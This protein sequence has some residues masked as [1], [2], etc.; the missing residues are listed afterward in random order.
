VIHNAAWYEVGISTR[1]QIFFRML[2]GRPAD[3]AS[4]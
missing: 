1:V 3:T 2:A 4:L